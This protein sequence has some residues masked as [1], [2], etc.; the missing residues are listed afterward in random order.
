MEGGIVAELSRLPG[1]IMDLWEWQYQ[2]AC[3]QT[4]DEQFFHPEGERGAARRRRDANAKAIC[5][6]CPVIQ[7]CREHALQVREPYGVWGG[8]TE[9]ER[10]GILARQTPAAS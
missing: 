6:S 1:P 7:Q 5:A 10:A 2:G 3:R 4:G 9:E 8:L